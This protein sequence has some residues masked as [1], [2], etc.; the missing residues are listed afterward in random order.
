MIDRKKVFILTIL[1]IIAGPAVLI[2]SPICYVPMTFVLL[3]I[4][5]SYIYVFVASRCFHLVVKSEELKSCER[6]SDTDYLIDIEN[7][8]YLVLPRVSFSVFLE[9]EDSFV[10][11]QYEYNFIFNPKEKKELQLS[12]NFPHLGKYKV[13]VSKIKFYGFIDMLHLYKKTRW[14]EELF[15]TPKTYEIYNYEINTTNPVFSVNYNVQH[16]IRGGEFNEVRQYIPGDSIKN[17]HWKLSAHS[18]EMFTRIINA[19][20]VSGITVFIDFSYKDDLDYNKKLDIYDCMV[21]CAYSCGVYSLNNDYGI[22]FIYSMFNNPTYYYP[23]TAEDLGGFIY[24]IPKSMAWEKCSAELLIA[25]YLNSVICFD[26]VIMLTSNISCDIIELLS[27][28]KDKGKYPML[29]YVQSEDSKQELTE[30]I[31]NCLAKNGISCFLVNSAKE[32]SSALGGVK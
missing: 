13:V 6:L 21:E 8:C 4:I 17:I 28:C 16:K 29:F 11:K 9:N 30:E 1:I 19:D 31:R 14:N 22:S 20:A 25:E 32:F 3:F 2:N 24:S 7:G 27:E 10:V 26:N 18:N 12:M 15:I 5:I 23:K